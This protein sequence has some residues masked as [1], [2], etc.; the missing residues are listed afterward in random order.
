MGLED[1]EH[2]VEVG[3]LLELVAAGAEGRARGELEAA[4]GLLALGR[5]VD[6]LLVEQAEHA[7]QA[8]VDLLDVGVVEG[9]GDDAREGRI[10]DGGG[11]AGLAD[12][13]ITYEIF[14][15]G[16]VFG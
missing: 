9:L 7:V 6:Q 2:A 5:E 16:C 1:L 15:H 14:G 10:D 11:A 3:L 13:D 8:A 12:Q 4:D